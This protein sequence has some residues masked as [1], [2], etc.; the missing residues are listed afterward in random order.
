MLSRLLSS[1][2]EKRFS[3]RYVRDFPVLSVQNKY[4]IERVRTYHNHAGCR[5]LAGEGSEST[6]AQK[7]TAERST[8]TLPTKWT[9][10]PENMEK[11]TPGPDT[12]LRQNFDSHQSHYIRNILAEYLKLG[13]SSLR[14]EFW[15]RHKSKECG[16]SLPGILLYYLHRS[17]SDDT[18]SSSLDNLIY[19]ISIATLNS[20]GLS[21]RD[22]D[23][24]AYILTAECGDEMTARL[25]ESDYQVQ[26]FVI[27]H[28]LDQRLSSVKSLEMMLI[29]SWGM[30]LEKNLSGKDFHLQRVK[31]LQSTIVTTSASGESKS[32]ISPRTSDLELRNRDQKLRNHDVSYINIYTF[33]YLARK[34]LTHSRRIWPSSMVNIAQMTSSFAI[35]YAARKNP[36]LKSIDA[37]MSRQLCDLINTLMVDF[38]FHSEAEPYLL[39][40][41]NWNSQ[42]ELLKLASKFKP[43]LVL[44]QASYRAIIQ[45]F[46]A[47]KKTEVQRKS[48]MKRSRSWPPWCVSQHGMDTEG[49]ISEEQTQVVMAVARLKEAGYGGDWFEE[50]LRIIGGQEFDG[51]PT[52]QSRKILS[53]PRDTCSDDSEMEPNLW[54]ARIT[55]TRDVHEAWSAFLQFK[56]NGGRPNQEM[57]LAMFEKLTFNIIR[58]HRKRDYSEVVPGDGLEVLAVPDNNY[59]DYYKRHLEPPSIEDLYS[60]MLRSGLRPEKRCLS[61]LVRNSR[62]PD[63]GLR[64]LRASGLS[65][66]AL[67]SLGAFGRPSDPNVLKEIPLKIFSDYIYLI[68]RFVPRLVQIDLTEQEHS[69][70]PEWTILHL[71]KKSHFGTKL[72]EPLHLAAYLLNTRRPNILPPWYSFFRA[73]TRE[74]SIISWEYAGHAKNDI[75]A[76][77]VLR[78]SLDDFSR[79]GLHLNTRGFS[80]ICHGFDK[81]I[82]AFFQSGDEDQNHIEEACLFIKN[83]FKKLSE[84]SCELYHL[85][86]LY[87]SIRGVHLHVY[88]RCLALVKDYDEIISTLEWM[89]RNSKYLKDILDQESP[90]SRLKF[91]RIFIVIAISCQGTSF[92]LS[93]RR[94]IASVDAWGGWPTDEEIDEYK[95]NSSPSSSIPGLR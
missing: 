85:P 29:C 30:I 88:M 46:A 41:H 22:V 86:K 76:W 73:L 56:K 68:C 48:I 78:S 4:Y 87:Q 52:I 37:F 3:C 1:P 44:S 62:T 7:D 95:H 58:E 47:H 5:D 54:A 12:S 32:S 24:W 13:E 40:V 51:T 28:I 61:F 60:D 53:Q 33:K 42:K 91:R 67:R 23:N 18:P 71:K 72:D 79:C 11:K 94:L 43:V 6:R 80:I 75:L 50:A 59:S 36:G 66:N 16:E 64:Y 31:N 38:S 2:W 63:D 83:E 10:F 9:N 49:L 39:I 19:D 82:R 57:Y 26:N 17:I 89:A 34:L 21:W 8:R 92:E 81:Y 93:A 45:V 20:R 15:D 65:M 14:K 35:S 27:L 84:N 69:G 74:N 70:I 25:C 55:A 90:D 77:K